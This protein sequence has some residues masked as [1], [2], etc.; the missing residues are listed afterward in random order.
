M[1]QN[2]RLLMR[3]ATNIDMEAGCMPNIPV[4]EIVGNKQVLVE[5]H[6]G[7]TAYDSTRISIKVKN[8]C[9][10][11]SGQC[12]QIAKMAKRQLVIQGHIEGISLA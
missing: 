12:L 5:N 3:F 8:G 9:V 4:I 1:K 11:V 6:L 7:I 10:H 2:K